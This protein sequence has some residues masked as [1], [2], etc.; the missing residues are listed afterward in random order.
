MVNEVP[1]LERPAAYIDM[2]TGYFP[3]KFV[4][5]LVILIAGVVLA[6]ILA[7]VLRRVIQKVTGHTKTELD[8]LIFERTE[9]PLFYV[10]LLIVLEV[11]LIPLKMKSIYVDKTLNSLI[12]LLV[13]Y[14]IM[15]TFDI[16]IDI[17]GRNFAQ[18]TKSDLDDSVLPLIHRFSKVFFALIGIIFILDLWGVAIT[19]VLASLGIAGI[20]VAFALQN[21]LGN[22]FGGVSI[23][24]DKSVKVGD[25]LKLE[26]GTTGVITDV[27]LRSTKMRT[28]DNEMVI[29]PNGKLADSKIQNLALPDPSA[30]VIVNFTVEYG[31]NVDKVKKTILPVLKKIDTF[32]SK[33]HEPS[34]QF[35]EMGDFAIKF[36]AIFWVKTY[37]ERFEARVIATEEIY[38]ALNKARIGIPFPTNVVYIKKRK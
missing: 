19:P 29:I 5:S 24:L 28:F 3:N 7:M 12:V 14:V 21:T 32:K 6:K 30:R 9:K 36:R 26:D 33:E 27:G 17:W 2:I 10:L 23:I 35:I 13:T 4:A 11:S 15:V 31:T 25:R 8:N 16:I 34:V 38:N 22:I 18:K 1:L 37:Q 20:A